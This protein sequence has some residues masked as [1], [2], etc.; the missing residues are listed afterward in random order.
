[1]T[2]D[3]AFV[4]VFLDQ[5]SAAPDR[6]H[7]TEVHGASLRPFDGRALAGL[8]ARA[9]GALRAR[10][11]VP[12]DRVALLAPNSAHWAAADVAMLA[13]GAIVVPLYARQE[14]A[15]LV[16]MMHDA[17]TTL[18]VCG[19]PALEDSVRAQWPDAPIAQLDTLFEGV[20]LN[21]PAVPRAPSDCVT[22]VYTS[23]TSG[24]PK[25][26]MI[27]RA[28]VDHM[29]P[30][31]R[32]GLRDLMGARQNE[33]R[34]FHYLPFCFMGSR[35]VL[36]TALYRAGGILVS[37]NLE[38]LAEELKTAKPHYF[39]NVP[40]L[41]ER[42]KKGVESK[43]AT[44]PRLVRALYARGVNASRRTLEGTASTLDRAA[45]LLAR[46]VVFER[47][48]QQIGAE[49]V[50]LICGSAPLHPDTQRWFEMLGIP[51]YQVYGLTETTAIVTMD[52][53]GQVV[54]GRVGVAIRGV[55]MRLGEGDELLIRGPNVFGGYWKKPEATVAALTDGWFHTGDQ[56]SVDAKGNLEIIGR[57]GNLLVAESGHN[58]APEPIEAKILAELGAAENCVVLG[59]GRPFLTA[60]VT[61]KVDAAE[62]QLALDRVNATLPHYRR[63]RRFH[64]ARE[65]FT[66]ESGL[67]TANQKLRRRA[68]EKH[69]AD[70]VTELYA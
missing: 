42:I 4:Q 12:G 7:L 56:C 29:L 2:E 60:I 11:V 34:V 59:H 3:R 10:G 21:E 18:V 54:P 51:V 46:R 62:V 31:T 14:P 48:R 37:T 33:E 53:P 19:T 44:Q 50:C 35:I 47:I 52:I 6:A 9:R 55:E 17:G 61:G 22:I 69:Y 38:N 5:L 43:L 1:M 25:G 68:I 66:I 24:E 41:L 49:L 15:E 36:W 13:E 64:V 67:L 58:I 32:D 40:A 28:G 70:A 39:L 26:V 23:G 45:L 57:V 16:A 65:T 8:I 27:T 30:V 20:P 63:V